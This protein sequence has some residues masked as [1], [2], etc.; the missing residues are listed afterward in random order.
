[1]IGLVCLVVPGIYLALRYGQYMY[2]IADRNLGPLEALKYSSD[3]TEGNRMSLF[4]LA[5]LSFLIAI[6]GVLCLFIGLLWAIPCLTLAQAFAYR[7]L[8]G[9]MDLIGALEQRRN[10]PAPLTPGFTGA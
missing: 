2:A 3:L 5:I 9:G 7:Y 10:N 1:M 4:A 6:A 8:Q